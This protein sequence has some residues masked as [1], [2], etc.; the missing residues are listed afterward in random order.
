MGEMHVV[1]EL[2]TSL[3]RYGLFAYSAQTVAEIGERLVPRGTHLSADMRSSLREWLSTGAGL[4]LSVASGA[5]ILADLG[6]I[7]NPPLVGMVITGLIVG[8]GG[9]F[10]G[11]WLA[12]LPRTPG[13]SPKAPKG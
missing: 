8:Q 13:Q 4:A 3:V 6:L 7:L 5:D 11:R 10:L 1:D 9:R 2:I 12:S